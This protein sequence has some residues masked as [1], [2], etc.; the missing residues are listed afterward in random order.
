LPVAFGSILGALDYFG[1]IV[2]AAS[3]ALLAVR[4]GMD[5]IGAVFLAVATAVGGGTLRDLLLGRAPVFWV[6]DPSYLIVATVTAL[7]VFVGTRVLALPEWLLI[8]ADAIGLA[9][10]TVIGTEVARTAGAPAV[11]MLLMGVMTATVGGIFRDILC[12]QPP[13]ILSREIYATAALAGSIA[14]GLLQ[15]AWG[16]TDLPAA[17]A[18]LVA[19]ALR[20]AAIRYHLE[21]PKGRA[22]R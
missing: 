1:T 10:F 5:P 8:W 19:F 21:L 17:T 13:L 16:L 18:F 11:I 22:A 12:A 2:F 9:T 7:V 20:A 6:V 3:G 15:A 14:Y 4:K